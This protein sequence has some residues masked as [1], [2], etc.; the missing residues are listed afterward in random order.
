MIIALG[1][2]HPIIADSAWIAPTAVV[3][4]QVQLGDDVGVWYGAVLRA[5][6]A[7]ITI[8]S[9]SNIQDGCVLHADP[10]RPITVGARVTVGHNTTLHGCTVSDDVMIGMGATV[11]NGAHI[12][13]G[14]LVAAGALVPQDFSVPERS[15]VVGAPAT[16]KRTLSDAEVA[17]ILANAIHYVDLAATHRDAAEVY[18]C[19]DS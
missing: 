11:L 18:A 13:A 6:D 3:V 5:D 2:L 1:A 14:T 9:R 19:A 4:G 8:G 17:S 10:D 16:V 15:L 12:G 7:A